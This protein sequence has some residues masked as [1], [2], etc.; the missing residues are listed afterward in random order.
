MSVRLK[1]SVK[2]PKKEPQ[3]LGIT[4]S[5]GQMCWVGA[6]LPQHVMGLRYVK[7]GEVKKKKNRQHSRRPVPA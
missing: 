1:T 4:K 2:T 5:A 6:V 7:S 3:L